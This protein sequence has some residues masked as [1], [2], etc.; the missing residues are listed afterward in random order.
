MNIRTQ[1]KL[2]YQSARLENRHNV[3]HGQSPLQRV[4]FGCLTRRICS[5]L[6][7]SEPNNTVYKALQ[8][9]KSLKELL[10]NG[11]FI[12]FGRPTKVFNY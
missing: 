3:E 9:D 12:V 6:K 1:F 2:A 11:Q 8:S 4:A 7:E 5:E 10:K